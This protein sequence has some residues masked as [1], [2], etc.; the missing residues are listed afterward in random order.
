[1]LQDAGAE[2]VG[3]VAHPQYPELEDDGDVI[4]RGDGGIGIIRVNWYTPDDLPTDP[5]GPSRPTASALGRSAPRACYDAPVNVMRPHP[6]N[7][8]PRPA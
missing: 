8:C 6:R 1:M 4:L 7:G 5:A 3:N 2:Q